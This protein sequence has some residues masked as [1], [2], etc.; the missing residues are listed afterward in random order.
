[1]AVSRVFWGTPLFERVIGFCPCSYKASDPLKSY[2]A[3]SSAS[4]Y[5]YFYELTE[6]LHELKREWMV[7]NLLC[8]YHI[9]AIEII[10][11][12][13]KIF[14]VKLFS[15]YSFVILQ[16]KPFW[17]FDQLRGCYWKK[18]TAK[19]EYFALR[20]SGEIQQWMVKAAKPCHGGW[21]GGIERE[22]WHEMG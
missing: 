12:S 22:Q 5:Y 20:K 2:S 10:L 13:I 15:V 21:R 18:P 19:T 1:M 8:K 6:V 11:L 14:S 4:P 7:T 3:E 16:R 17:M 9:N